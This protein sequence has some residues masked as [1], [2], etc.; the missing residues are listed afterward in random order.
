MMDEDGDTDVLAR[1]P[2]QP[3]ASAEPGLSHVREPGQCSGLQSTA[4][5]CDQSS[6]AVLRNAAQPSVSRDFCYN[7]NIVM[8]PYG[9]V[10]LLIKFG[11]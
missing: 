10:Y 3:A 4:P 6:A 2:G 7:F 5:C 9:F 11:T 1:A 8:T